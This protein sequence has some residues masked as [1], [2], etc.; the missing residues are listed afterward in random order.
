VKLLLSAAA[1]LALISCATI[2]NPAPRDIGPD[3]A[4]CI[5]PQ[6]QI[7]AGA[8]IEALRAAP[9]FTRLPDTA[10]VFLKP[11]R[12]A[13]RLLAVYDG[14]ELLI[15]AGGRFPAPPPGA[16]LISHTLAVS[17]A[18]RAV[19]AAIAQHKTGVPGAPALVARAEQIASG[20]H[21]W[22]AATGSAPLPLTGNAAN[23]NRLL[24]DTEY[25]TIAARVQSAV[26]LE[27]A[28][29]ART[30]DAARE[31]EE[32]LRATITLSAAAESRRPRFAALLRSI[33]V[34]R[35]DR[36]VRI[37]LTV[38]ADQM[39]DLFNALAP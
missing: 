35:D 16:T 12:N 21:I 5:P 2:Q 33:Q 31:L 26:S 29:L 24:R 30:A 27:S 10:R 14:G 28:S 13:S 39:T 36:T 6:T 7:L 22:I 25:T 11:Y 37:S 9:L 19:A 38:P 3:L 4:R 8:N 23:L 15:I 18:P 20:N 34:R 17:G 32:T 1:A